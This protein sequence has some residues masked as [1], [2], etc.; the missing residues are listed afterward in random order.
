MVLRKT[1]LAL[2]LLTVCG[3]CAARNDPASAHTG[4][5]AIAAAPS[6][7]ELPQFDEIRQTLPAKVGVEEYT[8]QPRLV[9]V[10][11]Y[12]EPEL[13]P[14]EKKALG[15]D[16]E[17]E[18]DELTFRQI[19]R[20]P[21]NGVSTLADGMKLGTDFVG[22]TRRSGRLVGSDRLSSVTGGD[23]APFGIMAYPR[24]GAATALIRVQ[25]RAGVGDPWTARVGEGAARS[26]ASVHSRVGQ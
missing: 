15:E 11:Q 6:R 23:R 20:G 17:P 21:E 7:A 10:P 18:F 1:L 2:S 12:V 26:K 24:L 22:S 19:E 25:P 3:G 14:E 9:V 5:P 13:T 4:N 8:D 16:Q